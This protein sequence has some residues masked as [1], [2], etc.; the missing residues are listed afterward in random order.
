MIDYWHDV[1]TNW[2]RNAPDYYTEDG[3]FRVRRRLTGREK[4]RAFY[5]WREDRGARTVVHSVHNFQAW[6]E[7]P[8][9]ATATGS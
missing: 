7:G 4:I 2:G 6:L 9:K 3:V 1:D 5:K 8:D